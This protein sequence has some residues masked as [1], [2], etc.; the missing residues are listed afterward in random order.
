AVKKFA[1]T[2][3]AAGKVLG[4]TSTKDTGFKKPDPSVSILD[5]DIGLLEI[6]VNSEVQQ[7]LGF[8]K[9]SATGEDDIASALDVARLGSPTNIQA[10]K[11]TVAGGA[12]A[13]SK[14]DEDLG[15]VEKTKQAEF[16]GTIRVSAPADLAQLGP[17]VSI[18]DIC[19]KARNK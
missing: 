15:K 16:S 5:Q 4:D 18:D 2:V 8:I 3:Q 9:A 7:L 12:R 6:T 14:L 19:D 13:A 17:F 1:E 10:M 11:V